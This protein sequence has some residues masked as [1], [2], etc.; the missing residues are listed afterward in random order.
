MKYLFSFLIIGFLL[1]PVAFS[2]AQEVTRAPETL[3]EA[4]TIGERTLW[5]LPEIFKGLWQEVIEIWRKIFNWFKNLWN[6][7]I[8]SWFQDILG[9]E[10]EKRKP[11][12]Q[13]K[14]ER[15]KQEM[16]E[17]IPIVTKS[18]WQRLKELIK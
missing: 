13:E 14:F 8:L 16:R 3:K 12:I 18:L 5:G 11:E 2:L 10:V 1:T 7:H 4:R 9:R 15:E 17:E 6:F